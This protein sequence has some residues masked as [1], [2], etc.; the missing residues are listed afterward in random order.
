M[1]ERVG[2]QTGGKL[3]GW[4]RFRMRGQRKRTKKNLKEVRKVETNGA[5]LNRQI[6]MER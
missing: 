3:W 2:R 6:E 4:G 5:R 1:L